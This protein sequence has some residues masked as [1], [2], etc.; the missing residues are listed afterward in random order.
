MIVE[1]GVTVKVVPVP[2]NVPPQDPVNHCVEAFPPTA[3]KVVLCPEQMDVVPEIDVGGV[4]TGIMA[5]RFDITTYC[6]GL[7]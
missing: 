3:V 2:T 7:L 6:F 4:A 1:P 5:V